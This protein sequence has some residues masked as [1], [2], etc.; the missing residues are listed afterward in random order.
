M[1]LHVRTVQ[2]PSVLLPSSGQLA[3]GRVVTFP[4]RVS[5]RPD[6]IATGPSRN[7]AAALSGTLPPQPSWGTCTAVQ[8]ASAASTAGASSVTPFAFAPYAQ[9]EQAVSD[10]EAAAAATTAIVSSS[11]AMLG[12]VSCSLTDP[13]Q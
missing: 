1:Y 8:A 9:T 5:V 13:G 4:S 3:R 2:P 11:I 7:T 12:C 6:G 10:V